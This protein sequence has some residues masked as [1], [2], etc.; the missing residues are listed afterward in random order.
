M[1]KNEVKK[2]EGGTLQKSQVDEMF[3]GSDFQIPIDAP[4]PQI[5]IMRET[6]QFE[7]PDGETTKELQGHIIFWHNANQYYKEAFGE[8]DSL[9]P[10]CASSDGIKPDGGKEI[11]ADTC[12]DCPLNQYGTASDGRGK[13]CQNTI[14]LYFLQDGEIIP[15]VIKAPPSSLGKKES[16]VRWLTNAPNVAAKAGV[17]VKYQPIHVKITLHKK[18]FDSGFSA[19]VVD[20]KTDRVLTP[21]NDM[22]QLKKLA[23]L[24]KDFMQS[25]KGRISEDVA[26]E[27]AEGQPADEEIPI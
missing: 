9:V 22:E 12:R 6:P 4:L 10:T 5:Q 17:G 18:E 3:G 25:Y 1:S 26:T 13:A 21:D 15:S 20:I 19:S 16:L 7:L 14:R 23:K 27:N 8:G 11:Q 2:P 24:Y